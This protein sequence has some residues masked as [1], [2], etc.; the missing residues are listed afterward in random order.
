MRART[1]LLSLLSV[2]LLVV[3]APGCDRYVG[4]PFPAIEGLREG[5]LT[6]TNAPLVVTFTKPIV[7]ETLAL[8]VVKLDTD[9]EGNLADERGPASEELS[10]FFAL[11]GLNPS[12]GTADLSPDG[13]VLTI[14]PSARFPVGPK[15]A[16]LVEPGLRSV[17]GEETRSR[18][19]IPFAY[20]FVCSGTRGTTVLPESGLYFALLEV[21]QPVGTQIQLFGRINVDPKTGR[22]R[23][24]FTN[25]DRITTPGR[26]PTP[27]ASSEACRLLPT[28]ECVVPSLRA[29]NTEEFS[30]FLPNVTPPVGYSF[31]VEGCAE[32]QGENVTSLA[33]AP[34]N[35]VVQQP[36]VTVAGLVIT[37]QLTRGPDGVIRGNGAGTGDQV[38]LGTSQL[39][40]AGGTIA[41]RSLTPAEAPPDIPG[42]P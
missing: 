7:P 11:D 20:A 33:T 30:D 12:G 13:M 29:G 16:L 23:G 19:R 36:A 9:V 14:T 6:D 10:P 22:L 31:T 38:V 26:C 35:L 3:L 21:E 32:D 28:P 37:T 24:Q 42:P 25:A 1:L 15:L 18:K 34:A 2:I 27:C 40:R 39:G 41:M 17:G 8:R 5:V 4:P